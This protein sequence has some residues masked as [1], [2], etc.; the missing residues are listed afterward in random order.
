MES[1]RGKGLNKMSC[2]C[3]TTVLRI[4]AICLGFEYWQDWD[5][6]LEKH[7]EEFHWCPG[8]F[9]SA[10]CDSYSRED[11]VGYLV[12]ERGSEP[13]DR[14]DM[15]LYPDVVQSVPGP[16]L[17]YYLEEIAPLP[18][19]ENTYNDNDCARPLSQ[20]EKEKYLPLFLK[21]FPD[22]TLERMNDVHY[23]HYEW[24]DGSEA[25]YFY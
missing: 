8:Y 20:E 12:G 10:I 11:Y 5:E 6:F 25:F 24:Y 18:P 23:C 3:R 9:A 7:K 14:L 2:W 15:D 17:D 16:F 13:W 21:L 19:E 1:M 22:F 4:P